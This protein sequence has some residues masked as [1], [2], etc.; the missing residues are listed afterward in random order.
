MEINYLL[1]FT[2]LFLQ[3]RYL[4]PQPPNVL[5][6]LVTT[7]YIKRCILILLQKTTNFGL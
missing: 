4:L 5:S 7:I 3:Y 6:V 1:A 2:L